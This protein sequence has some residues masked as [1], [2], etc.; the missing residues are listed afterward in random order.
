MKNTLPIKLGLLPI[1]L[2]SIFLLGCSNLPSG[3]G[4]GEE[5]A[6]VAYAL[7][8]PDGQI[9]EYSTA[10][11]RSGSVVGTLTLPAP[12]FVQQFATDRNG[13]IYVAACTD[14]NGPGQVFVYPPNSSG[15]GAPS[16]TI[17]IASCEIVEFAV[18]PAG[19]YLYVETPVAVDAPKTISV[20]SAAAS[21]AP[22][23]IRMIQ[24]P[25]ALS[26]FPFAADADGNIFVPGSASSYNGVIY[27]YG[28]ESTGSDAPIRTI[29]FVN[30]VP[31][32]LAVDT[33]GDIFAIVAICCNG[34]NWVIEE[35]A[36]GAVGAA[37]P[38]NTIDLPPLSAGTT[39]N[40]GFLQL[41]AA[42]NIFASLVLHNPI[43]QS[44][45]ATS[46]IYGF[47]PTATGQAAP[48]VAINLSGPWSLFALN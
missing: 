17:E 27:V 43:V 12:Y 40:N 45:P 22:A 24:L 21:G 16:K 25:M 39:A 11:A 26:G 13:Q 28:P 10:P 19:R 30:E 7:S 41:D 9:N 31:T 47:A 14:G 29:T 15:T 35:F 20:Y 18:D 5:Q 6:T 4:S 42:S 44:S 2:I 48:S 23:A 8:F 37:A 3:N 32:G 36:P 46:V 34:T 33:N 38:L 1:V